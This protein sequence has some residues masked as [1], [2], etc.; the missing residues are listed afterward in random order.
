MPPGRL[1]NPPPAV[2]P[3]LP[4]SVM[5]RLNGCAAFGAVEVGGGAENVRA[6]REPELT[7]PPIRASADETASIN[8]NASAKTMAMAWTMP[9]A[10]WVNFMFRFPGPRHGEAPL[11]WAARPESEAIIGKRGCGARS[12]GGSRDLPVHRNYAPQPS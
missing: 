11:T 8:G 4:G 2:A 10:A 12:R 7:P 1:K 5:V 3:E 9:R 6:P